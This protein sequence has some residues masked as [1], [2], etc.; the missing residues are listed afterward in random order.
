MLRK[1]RLA[2]ALGLALLVAAGTLVATHSFFKN[3]RDE[4][5]SFLEEIYDSGGA[6]INFIDT[7]EYPFP[8][9]GHKKTLKIAIDESVVQRHIEQ[10]EAAYRFLSKVVGS[11]V[12]FTKAGEGYKFD[13][14][15][16]VYVGGR[17]SLVRSDQPG[18]L[19]FVLKL[20]SIIKSIYNNGND[21]L[22]WSA[23]RG[24]ALGKP[25]GEVFAF[26]REFERIDYGA[27]G[28]VEEYLFRRESV[29]YDTY[30]MTNF[31][32]EKDIVF[33]SDFKRRDIRN[34]I[35]DNR[36][37]SVL[38]EEIYHSI[39]KASDID[40]VKFSLKTKL[41]DHDE[42]MSKSSLYGEEMIL[43]QKKYAAQ[44][45]C[46]LDVIY[47]KHL[48][49]LTEETFRWELFK[50]GV[51]TYARLYVSAYLDYLSGPNELFDQ[52]CW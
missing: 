25:Y 45:L 16:Y 29:P 51:L 34:D 10:I 38:I 49:D 6:V 35:F 7:R 46:P 20:E 40:N 32:I 24:G 47:L 21:A 11:E 8:L 1:S 19:D 39:S 30:K 36:F 18:I 14:D 31:N 42:F 22:L 23:L 48:S 37:L 44:G 3:K 2:L 33:I 26:N 28:G 50:T 17:S 27:I 52:R 43:E 9:K 13:D 5:I 4:Y 15:I 41:Y 12:R